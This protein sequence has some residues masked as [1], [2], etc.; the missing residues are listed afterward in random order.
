LSCVAALVAACQYL[1]ALHD[2]LP[3]TGVP[4]LDPNA[5][6]QIVVSS[7]DRQS[8]GAVLPVTILAEWKDAGPD[9]DTIG[10][11][12]LTGA[13]GKVA[14]PLPSVCSDGSAPAPAQAPAGDGGAEGGLPAALAEAGAATIT[15]CIAFK[16]K[17]PDGIMSGQ[18]IGSYTP[19][20]SESAATLFAALYGK[21]DCTG[22]QI[23]SN[24][25]FEMLGGPG[26][27]AGID[28]TTADASEGGPGD[29]AAP[30]DGEPEAS[31]EGGDD[32]AGGDSG[33]DGEGDDG[34]GDTGTPPGDGGIGDAGG[35]A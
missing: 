14:F 13:P 32:S 10:C 22:P 23:A 15:Q 1:P 12:A 24:Y 35:D 29:D 28:G 16:S 7:V 9:G 21:A 25:A 2:D 30:A 6:V 17:A 19:Q 8:P 27:E 5:T 11:V 34:G 18:A 3:D 31:G 4:G 33:D 26:A 20:G